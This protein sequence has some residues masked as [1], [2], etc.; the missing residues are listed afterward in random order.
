[1]FD[2]SGKTALVTGANTGIGYHIARVLA[3]RGAKV[4]LGCRDTA[5]AQAARK[6]YR[7]GGPLPP[8]LARACPPAPR[9]GFPARWGGGRKRWRAARRALCLSAPAWTGNAS[10]GSQTSSRSVACLGPAVMPLL[11]TLGGS[12]ACGAPGSPLRPL[13]GARRSIRPSPAFWASCRQEARLKPGEA[14]PS[15]AER[16]ERGTGGGMTGTKRRGAYL[17]SLELR[18]PLSRPGCCTGRP[19]RRRRRRAS[20]APARRTAG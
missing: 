16:V 3:D 7:A 14:A 13:G 9:T 10:S 12:S 18:A 1:M 4:L 11:G 20:G 8:V 15:R 19:S 6:D 17:L 5:K 2:L